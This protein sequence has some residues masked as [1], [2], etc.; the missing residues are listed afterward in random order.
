MS[1]GENEIIPARM[2]NEYAYCARLGY[3]M[4]VDGVFAD[5][6]DTVHGRFVHRRVDQAPKRRKAAE[7]QEAEVVHARSVQL[8]GEACGLTAKID[9]VEAQ[10]AAATPVDYKRS[11]RPHT[12]QGAWEPERVQL[13]A[14]GL[15][16]RE[17]GFT[18][19]EGFLYFAGSGERVRVA[20]DDDLVARTLDL[21][22]SFRDA[23]AA[24]ATP[25]PLDDSP[26]CPRCSLAPVCLPDEVRSLARTLSAGELRR[27]YPACDDALPLYVTE[28]RA[29]VGKDGERLLVRIDDA[30]IAE[31]RLAET[32]TVVL[33]GSAQVSTQVVQVLCERGIPLC[34]L[35]SGGW[36][37]GCTHGLP[38]KNVDLR[39]RQH[40]TAEDPSACLGLARRFVSAK[41]ANQR[42]QLRRNHPEPG[43]DLLDAL[44][45]DARNALKAPGLESL[46]G[47]EGTAARRYFGAFAGLIKGN[48]S[49]TVEPFDFEGRNKRPPKD[50]V[51]ALLS[52]GYAMLTREWTTALHVVGLDPYLGFFHQ[53]RHGK[54]SLA[55]DLM[56]EFRPLVVDSAVLT[57]LNNGEVGPQH[58]VR[59]LG[60]AGLTP[61]GRRAFVAAFER[62]LSQEI[63]HPVFGYKV[64]YRRVF[65]VQ[66]R[67]LGRF[68]T[69]EIPQ[70]PSFTTR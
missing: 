20:F 14:Q 23:A 48:G 49:G 42:T 27:L 43:G 56:E 4:W 30:V 1:W 8:T 15:I 50:P 6:A 36:F 46:L 17:N 13:C 55:L 45:G 26:K 24:G 69:G 41:I 70:Y 64:S 28:P 57:A 19:D 58:F 63:T 16:L 25:P 40:R 2:L 61:E 5:S 33:F 22:R 65:E 62:R 44:R 53:P 60:S 59:A 52:F 12:P 68:L 3:L 66:A 34:Y 37:Y 29:R 47:V 38:A 11:K 67:L 31:A 51:N 21:A 54:P 18:C 9:L 10:G 32:S 39:R 7:P 35:S